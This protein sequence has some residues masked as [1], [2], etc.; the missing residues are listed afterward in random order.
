MTM[1]LIFNTIRHAKNKLDHSCRDTNL[2]PKIRSFSFIQGSYLAVL[3]TFST[4]GVF[5][6]SEASARASA[7][8]VVQGQRGTGIRLTSPAYRIRRP[9]AHV[10]RPAVARPR[11]WPGQRPAASAA[12]ASRSLRGKLVSSA[13]GVPLTLHKKTNIRIKY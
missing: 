9:P 10:A 8:A 12:S 11:T 5:S 4:A 1:A 6:T 7:A 13:L 2:H 3:G